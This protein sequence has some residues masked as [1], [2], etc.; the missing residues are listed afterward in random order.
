VRLDEFFPALYTWADVHGSQ[1]L[2]GSILIPVA[3]SVLARV[4]KA[5]RTDQDGRLIASAFIGLGILGVLLEILALI[6][7]TSVLRVDIGSAN[8]QLLAA[9]LLC[10]G[11]LLIGMRWVFP[12]SELSSVQTLRDILVFLAACGGVVWFCSKFYGWGILFFGSF[13]QLVVVA[14]LGLLL[15]RR[16]YRRAFGIGKPA[17]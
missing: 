6:L 10:L 17:I 4:G 13:T 5:G 11:L 9:P 8:V 16:L 2:L 7:A 3:G 12:L 1:I 14:V 15:L